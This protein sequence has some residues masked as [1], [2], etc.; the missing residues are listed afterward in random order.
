T[1]YYRIK[2]VNILGDGVASANVTATT[3]AFTI[4]AKVTGVT[5]AAGNAWVELNWTSQLDV[6]EYLVKRAT[7]LGGPY[8]T[9]ATVTTTSYKDETV[10]NNTNYYYVISAKNS[11]GEGADS[12]EIVAKP[13]NEEYAYWKFDHNNTTTLV[14]DSWGTNHG[15]FDPAVVISTNTMLSDITFNEPVNSHLNNSIRFRGRTRSYVKLPVGTISDLN[16]FTISLWYRQVANMNGARIFDFGVGEDYE[17]NTPATTRKMMFLIPRSATTGN[18]ITYGVQNGGTL[19]QL[20]GNT[21][22]TNGQ[23]YHIVITQAG[24]TVTMYV[25]GTQVGQKTDMTIKPADLGSTTVNYLGRSRFT[26][27]SRIDGVLDEFKIYN[28]ALTGTEVNQL[29]ASVLP[30]AFLDFEAQKQKTGSI[31]LNWST[32]SEKN[33]SHFEVLRSADG[34]FFDNIAHV[35]G[36][37][38]TSEVKSYSFVDRTPKLGINYYSLKQIDLDG[39]EAFHPKVLA[40]SASLNNGADLKMYTAREKLNVQVNANEAASFEV[41]LSDMTGRVLAKFANKVVPG[42]NAFEFPLP[43]FGQGTYIATYLSKGEKKS[44]KLIIN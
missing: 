10:I 8:T 36:N 33:N 40:I 29:R 13:S 1:Y 23:W 17:T 22:L 27:S 31:T 34:K 18:R 21:T 19:Q 28:K 11:L 42:N 6:P 3:A 4:P 37:L 38:N 41:F 44:I 9:L 2:G 39:K 7:T 20:E 25:N 16:D 43:K 30:V 5:V 15:S 35:N 12:D 14:T 32:A 26:T 24:N